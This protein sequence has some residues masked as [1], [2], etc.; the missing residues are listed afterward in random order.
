MSF[1]AKNLKKHAKKL[2]FQIL[3]IAILDQI[4][5]FKKIYEMLK[6]EEKSSE[7]ATEMIEEFQ[8]EYM[9]NG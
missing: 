3:K 9:K 2:L 7:D 8:K 4:C 1:I 5:H 6:A